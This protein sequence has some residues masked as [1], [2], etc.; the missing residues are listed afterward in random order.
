MNASALEWTAAGLFLFSILHTFF[1]GRLK[2]YANSKRS[3]ITKNF[4]LYLADVEVVFG[5][6]AV[7][8]LGSI[9]LLDSS[10]EAL[11]Y[12]E[13]R[14]FT[15]PLFVL[16]VM[17]ICATR[18]ILNFASH[19]L[20]IVSKSLPIPRAISF[21]WTVLFLG[22]LLGSFITEPAAM[23]VTALILLRSIFERPV[24]ES[25]K[26]AT[27]GV[28]FV[29]ISI[30]GTLT[31]YAAPPVLM[32]ADAFNWDLKFMLLNFG[33][34]AILAS[35]LTTSLVTYQFRKELL[36]LPSPDV[37]DARRAKLPI[38]VSLMNLLFLAATV[39]AS[40]SPVVFIG[41][42]LFFVGFHQITAEYQNKLQ[43]RDGVLVAFFLS[44]LIVLGG[45]QQWWLSPVLTA[46]HE[47]PLYVG[48]IGL[49]AITDNAALTYLGSLVPSLSES[50]KYALVAGSVVGGGLTVIANA[51]NPA[52][53]G[54]LS[55]TFGNAGMSPLLLLR[56]AFVPT[57]I[58]AICF[59]L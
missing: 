27:L 36:K 45:L 15:E 22:P 30:G 54:I 23:T 11:H 47:L 13:S 50:A 20:L 38:W 59:W 7:L 10:A 8:L 18:P 49:T 24:S 48:A 51:P 31:P 19:A 57:L 43:L 44:G 39:Y 29:N 53:Y 4:F 21:Y 17:T 37:A 26:Y 33:W 55:P 52:G 9:V 1:V 35:L 56:A 32:V 58:S 46:L 2:R 25:F 14:N 5:L 34:K 42:F 6:W 12:L 16:V 40:H 3:P 41:T 28:L